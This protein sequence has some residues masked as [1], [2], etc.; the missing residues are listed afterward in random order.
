M[1]KHFLIARIP[2][3]D[4]KAFGCG[5]RSRG[6]KI[7]YCRNLHIFELCK[8]SQMLTRDCSATDK[9]TSEACHSVLLAFCGCIDD[10][11]KKFQIHLDNPIPREGG[12]LCYALRS[13]G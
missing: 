13:F 2:L 8:R 5:F 7:T 4:A 9:D 6:R 3:R 10:L 12:G 1:S 11:I